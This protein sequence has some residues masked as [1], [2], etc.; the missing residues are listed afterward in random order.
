MSGAG[1][2]PLGEAFA[3]GVRAR[4][5]GEMKSFLPRVGL[6]AAGLHRLTEGQKLR[7]DHLLRTERECLRRGKPSL[8]AE[9]APDLFGL[10]LTTPDL[11]LWINHQGD[12]LAAP[13]GHA[14][15]ARRY[16]EL[17]TRAGNAAQFLIKTHGWIKITVKAGAVALVHLD[18]AT[19]TAGSAAR[20]LEWIEQAATKF[21]AIKVIDG[22]ADMVLL[23]AAEAADYAG[24]LVDQVLADTAA[25]WT[26]DRQ[27]LDQL[28]H[29]GHELI[30]A[31]HNTGA[32]HADLAGLA[33]RL[34]ILDRAMLF[35]ADEDSI[36]ATHVGGALHVDPTLIGLDIRCRKDSAYGGMQHRRLSAHDAEPTLFRVAH[37]RLG[38]YQ[39]LSFRQTLSDGRRRL[40]TTPLALQVPE[41]EFI[42]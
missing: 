24:G 19:V 10:D 15:T 17:D 39:S 31:V 33:Q 41:D 6:S 36:I 4:F 30:K 35:V 42:R 13:F 34:G 26:F 38:S 5:R 1:R 2:K 11:L 27:P 40:L 16:L 18:R 20:F 23:S 37:A 21:A 28:D 9:I 3:E 12:L 29:D 14:E 22:N 25:Q 32:N 7:A 8:L